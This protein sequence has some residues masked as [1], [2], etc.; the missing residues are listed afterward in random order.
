MPQKSP[1]FKPFWWRKKFKRKRKEILGHNMNDH[2]RL[3][4]VQPKTK[5]LSIYMLLQTFKTQIRIFLMKPERFLSIH[6]KF[7]QKDCN[8]VT[9][10]LKGK[11]TNTAQLVMTVWLNLQVTRTGEFVF[12]LDSQHKKPYEVLVLGKYRSSTDHVVR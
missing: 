11:V 9:L 8:N 2:Q 10:L 12:P 1:S 6:W 5:I 3:G 4:I 7:T